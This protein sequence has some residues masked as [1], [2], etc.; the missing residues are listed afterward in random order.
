MPIF[1]D[2]ILILKL[3]IAKR[4]LFW[5][6]NWAAIAIMNSFVIQIFN[7][8]Q[9]H[10]LKIEKIRC[11]ELAFLYL[12]H[13][14]F[15]PQTSWRS[16]LREGPL[17]DPC[18]L[19]KNPLVHHLVNALDRNPHHWNSERRKSQ[20]NFILLASAFLTKKIILSLNHLWE[21]KKNA[22]Q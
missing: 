17:S 20:T 3:K 16:F 9:N 21:D 6:F 15:F 4:S 11:Y 1:T 13:C 10:S 5:D 18:V 8:G 2:Q 19:P 14:T 7:F 22:I 12:S